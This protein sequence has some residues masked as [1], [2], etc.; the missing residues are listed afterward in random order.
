MY[1]TMSS[2]NKQNFWKE[3]FYTRVVTVRKFP[4]SFQSD[5]YERAFR[6][7]YVNFRRKM[8][9]KHSYKLCKKCSWYAQQFQMQC[10][11]NVK[12]DCTVG[13]VSKY[14]IS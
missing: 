5:C 4:C 14:R 9:A 12:L 10:C 6:I 13:S 2:K 1:G 3:F 8:N 7:S 11:S